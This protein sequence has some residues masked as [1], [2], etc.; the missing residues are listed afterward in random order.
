[1][2]L[3]RISSFAAVLLLMLLAMG[4]QAVAQLDQGSVVGFVQDPSGAVIANAAVTLTNTDIGQVFKTTTDGSG[5]FAFTPVKI[6]NYK[7]SA[8]ATGFEST[9]YPSLHVSIQQRL[10]VPITLKPGAATETVT[11]TTELPLL[12]TQETSVGQTMDTETINNVPLNGRNWVYIA[13]LAPGAALPEGSRGAGKGDFNANGQRAEENNFILDGVDNNANVVDFF[14]GAS[15]VVNPPP[16]AL[17]EFKVQT[18]DY[19][20]EFGHSAGAVVNASIKSGTNN[21]HGSLWEYVRNTA[22]DTYSWTDDHSASVPA[23]HENQFGATLGGPVLKNKL[24]LFADV[25]ANRVVYH[26]STTFNVPTANER[27]GDFSELLD[28]TL[29]GGDAIKLYKQDSTN[30]TVPEVITN[31]CLVAGGSCTAAGATGLPTLNSVALKVLSLYPVA[32]TNDGK[33]YDNYTT[34]LPVIDNT[35]QWDVRA[36]WTASSKDSAYSRFSYYNEVGTSTPPLGS[37]LDGGSYGGGKTKNLGSNF[38]LSETHLFTQNLVNEFRFGF[39]Y[40]H[41]GFQQPNASDSSFASDQGFGGI[42]SGTLNGGLPY[43]E[44]SGTSAPAHFGAATWAATDEHNDVYQILDNV[45]KVQ[46]SQTLKA[47]VSY[48]NIRVFTLQP[49]ESR[50]VYTYGTPSTSNVGAANTGYGLAAFLL[51]EMSQAQLSNSMTTRNERG[52]FAAYF[53]D[54]WRV[55]HNLTVNLGLRYEYFQAMK[56]LSGYQAS[57]YLTSAPSY[58]SSTGNGKATGTYAIP[59]RTKSY[60]STIM[61]K[62]GYDTAIEND[63]MSI[64][65][66]SNERLQKVPLVNLAPR[67]GLSWQ[68]DDKTVLRSGFGFFYGGLESL[69]YWSNLSENYPF[70]Y[71][72]TF[73]S[74]SCKKNYCPTLLDNSNYDVNISNGFS[75]ILSNGFA[76]VVTGLTMRGSDAKLKSAYT[77]GWNLTLQRSLT[78]EWSGTVAYVGNT[79]R[80]LPINIDP[81]AATALANP[82]TNT[83]HLNPFPDYSGSAYTGYAGMSDY[84]SLQSK[85]EKRM[86]HGYNVY[87]SYTWS[88]ALDDAVTPLGSSGDGN[89][90]QTTLIPFKYDYSNA[91]FD[92]RHRFTFNGLYELPFG[93]G[94]RFINSNRI[95]DLLAGGWSI[96]AMFSAQ[97]GNHFTISTSGISAAGGFEN[98]PFAYKTQDQYKAGGSASN[99]ASSVKNRTHWYNP[100]SFSN[101]WDAGTQT[102]D[103]ATNEHYIATDAVVTDF[104]SVMGY[105]GGKRDNAVGPG[106]ER[107][108]MS[109][110][111]DFDIY[112]EHKLSFRADIFNVFNTPSLSNPSTANNSSSG[113]KITAYRSIQSNAPDS[114]FMQLSLRYSF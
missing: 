100:C 10:S 108:N 9:A 49:Q 26:S 41:T 72:A 24:F 110:F 103:G 22:L 83:Q 63:G 111:K 4:K 42:P 73:K 29:V 39:N 12:Q 68:I 52:N 40:L 51:D 23:Y 3:K 105:A 90:R 28:S 8:S 6:G 101:P 32:N 69:G 84:N 85:L 61:T 67:V 19:S 58:D 7:I 5:S 33:L 48:Q 45:S 114:R 14:N 66:D 109:I 16:D 13:Q 113:G 89:Y 34:T 93:K 96:N 21:I 81:N 91:S 106:F 77:E 71:A 86:S 92:V 98:G 94:K 95:A 55:F 99:C 1:M 36:D 54:D 79:S 17:A 88:H 20:A 60:A 82:S 43:V 65:W 27:V 15:Y 75:T 102:I 2:S 31:N 47:G 107:V 37:V 74:A 53:Q 64:L 38:M 57:F 112:R 70:Q 11:V 18:S 76:S 59:A 104:A 56:E 25:Q 35:A 87:A 30:A 44:F 97:T 46:G 80:H 62:Y 78:Q 50:G